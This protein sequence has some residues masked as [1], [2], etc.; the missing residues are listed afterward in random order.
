MAHTPEQEIVPPDSI[1]AA[2]QAE[3]GRLGYWHDQLCAL[4]DAVQAILEGVG[5]RT[6]AITSERLALL[7]RI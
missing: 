1:D 4:R 6:A 5:A 3:E 2:L 7:K